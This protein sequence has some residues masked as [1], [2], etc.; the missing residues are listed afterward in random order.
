MLKSDSNTNIIEL[1]KYGYKSHILI[2]FS[3]ILL[4]KK[5]GSLYGYMNLTSFSTNCHRMTYKYI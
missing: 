1:V 5:S 3:Q 2:D 4:I